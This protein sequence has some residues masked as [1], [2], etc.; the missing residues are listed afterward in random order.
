MSAP[1]FS[2][3]RRG[4]QLFDLSLVGERRIVVDEVF[5]L[6][7][8][9][10]QS[11]EVEVES[12]QER[13]AVC[14]SDLLEL[15]GIE[16]FEQ[17]G[18]NGRVGRG[19][20]WALWARQGWSVQW[21][22][23]PVFAS[24]PDVDG[25]TGGGLSTSGVVSS[26]CDPFAEVVD[27]RFGQFPLGRH[28]E[29]F[30][31]DGLQQ[32]AVLWFARYDGGTGVST[33]EQTIAMIQAQATAQFLCQ[34]GFG[35]VTGVAVFDE[36]RANLL[37]KERRVLLLARVGWCFWIFGIERAD[38]EGD[39]RGDQQARANRVREHLGQVKAHR[40]ALSWQVL[41]EAMTGRL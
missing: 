32:Q 18:I 37:F 35:R 20:F 29:R 25:R 31:F 39:Q 14:E 15:S 9:W 7:G 22:V 12:S 28:F 38:Q 3:V 27:H 11:D 4:H 8:C 1:A 21:L 34:A 36:D 30:V 10:R 40:G 24:G 41:A 6:I 19:V 17:E 13:G 23:G 33:F 2:E 5:D 16:S 26:L